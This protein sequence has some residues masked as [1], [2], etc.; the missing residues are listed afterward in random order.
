MVELSPPA[1]R[2]DDPSTPN[3]MPDGAPNPSEYTLLPVPKSEKINP[4][5]AEA[6]SPAARTIKR[7]VRRKFIFKRIS[8]IEDRLVRK[9]VL[10]AWAIPSVSSIRKLATE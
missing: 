8:P 5:L 2:A 4:A 9:P 1:P 6:D 7:E 10:R 3:P